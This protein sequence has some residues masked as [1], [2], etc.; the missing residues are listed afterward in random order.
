MYLFIILIHQPPQPRFMQQL[1]SGRSGAQVGTE[2]TNGQ[3]HMYIKGDP[4]EI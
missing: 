3:L 4:A 1:R 2:Y